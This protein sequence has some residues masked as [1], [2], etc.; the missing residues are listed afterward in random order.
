MVWMDERPLDPA[1][2]YLLKQATRVVTAEVNRGLVLNQIGIGR[3]SRPRKPLVFD[4]YADNRLDRQLHP[5]RSGHQL[6]GR[7]R[8]DHRARAGRAAPRRWRGR[9]PP[10]GW[11]RSR[12]AR[13]PTPRRVEAVRRALEDILK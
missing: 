3:R 2:V 13:P 11:R 10:S 5:D 7:R 12:A 8:H 4:R 1:R 9:A 6:H